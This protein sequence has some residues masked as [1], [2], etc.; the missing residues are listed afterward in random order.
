[1]IVLRFPTHAHRSVCAEVLAEWDAERG[2]N[3]VDHEAAQRLRQVLNEMR[4]L[5]PRKL[6][7]HKVMLA[8]RSA[9]I[10][11]RAILRGISVRRFDAD[12][13]AIAPDLQCLH[14][15]LHPLEHQARELPS[16]VAE[17]VRAVSRVAR[18]NRNERRLHPHP[19]S[20]R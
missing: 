5:T 6:R 3:K 7:T 10:L 2:R 14:E 17:D 16:A 18:R 20:P 11:A 12:D 4:E 8:G 1:M 9:H 19:P 15:I 13:P